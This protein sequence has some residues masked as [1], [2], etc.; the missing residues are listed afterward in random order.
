MFLNF[1]RVEISQVRAHGSRWINYKRKALLRVVDRYGA[2]LHHLRALSEDESIKSVDR[3]RLKG[4]LL[5]WR[6][7][8]MLVGSALYID[9]LYPV[10]ILSLNVTKW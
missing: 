3:Q 1:R 5:K 10:A 8:K 6:Q 7:A 2:Y 4:Y 9:V